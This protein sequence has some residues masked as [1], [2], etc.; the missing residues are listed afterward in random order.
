MIFIFI[1]KYLLLIHEIS[2][3]IFLPF[4]ISGLNNTEQNYSINTLINDIFYRDLYTIL[5]IGT[6]ATEVLTLIRPDNQTIFLNKNDCERK[7]MKFFDN[8][9]NLYK[10]KIFN[11]K[12]SSSFT[13]ITTID[14]DFNTKEYNYLVK[15]SI[16]FYDISCLNN[17][18]N[19]KSRIN[20]EEFSFILERKYSTESCARL[21]IGYSKNTQLHIINQLKKQKEF[22]KYL[23]TIKFLPNLKGHLIFGGYP[24][25]YENNEIYNPNNLIKIYTGS[26]GNV[27]LPWSLGFY[28]AYF[29]IDNNDI[30][31]Q[32]YVLCY[33]VF[34]FGLIKATEKYKEFILKY[35]FQELIDK[36]I[37]KMEIT[38]KTIF[39]G[40]ASSINSNGIFTMFTCDKKLFKKNYINKF[41]SL[42]LFNQGF[43]YTFELTY[44]ELFMEVNNKYYFLVIFSDDNSYHW[45]FGIPFLQKY[46]FVFN[47]D[48]YT[49]GFYQNY[50]E[51]KEK[52]EDSK[53][54]DNKKSNY[55]TKK[56][57][58]IFFEICF[59]VI[60]VGIGY[61][62]GKK[63][64]EQRKKRANELRDDNYE[65]YSENNNYKNFD[66]NDSLIQNNYNKKDTSTN[67]NNKLLE[68]AIKF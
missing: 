21:G 30:I 33:L 56:N 66:K 19:C 54:I 61:Y 60:L 28:L 51:I 65:Y 11:Y 48:E 3:I 10:N 8:K 53:K 31:I 46:E 47:Y 34:N 1:I 41:P 59:C 25:E 27:F 29:M 43:N 9:I 17:T 2:T 22:T 4:E 68:L 52:I 13:T 32:K 50:L 67:D 64:H 16:S 6:P 44:K 37:C 36:N 14:P 35:Y 38:D 45:I 24:H 18:F 26:K 40:K 49:I 12:K 7:K 57:I 39:D 55:V 15:D 20:F 5:N 62:I 58:K 23:M 63:I 42:K